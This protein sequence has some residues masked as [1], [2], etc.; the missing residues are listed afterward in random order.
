MHEEAFRC[1]FGETMKELTHLSRA[2]LWFWTPPIFGWVGALVHVA[3]CGFNFASRA[4]NLV[5]Q[6]FNPISNESRNFPFP[7]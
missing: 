3:V 6:I 4:T 2:S 5:L 7:L 1:V